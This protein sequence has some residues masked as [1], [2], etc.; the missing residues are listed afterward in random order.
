MR[1][2]VSP[3]PWVSWMLSLP[4]GTEATDPWIPEEG[5]LRDLVSPGLNFP[6]FKTRTIFPSPETIE[7]YGW[8]D[9]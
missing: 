5:S 3:E 6:T 1:C 4:Y 2:P 8:K 9:P 7:F